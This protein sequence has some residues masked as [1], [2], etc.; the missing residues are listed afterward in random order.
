[1]LDFVVEPFELSATVFLPS[2]GMPSEY[3]ESDR[4]SL[5][6][7]VPPPIPPELGLFSDFDFVVKS[8]LNSI[9]TRAF[10]TEPSLDRLELLLFPAEYKVKIFLSFNSFARDVLSPDWFMDVLFSSMILACVRLP[11]ILLSFADFDD[12]ALEPE[13]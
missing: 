12:E 1:M 3:L 7:I 5:P 11:W 6:G 9:L 4:M 2:A 8:V 10:P 13:L